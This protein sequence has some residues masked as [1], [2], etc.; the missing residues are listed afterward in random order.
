MRWFSFV[1]EVR[2]AASSLS[3]LPL[4]GRVVPE[5]DDPS[6]REIFV[7]KYRL[8]YRVAKEATYVLGLIHGAR[9]LAALFGREGR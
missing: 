3:H 9:D 7:K 1:R 2:E 6:I 4:R 8:I 5:L